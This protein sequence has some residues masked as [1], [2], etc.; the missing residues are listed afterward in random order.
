[1]KVKKYKL[2][3]FLYEV[4]PIRLFSEIGYVVVKK[5]QNVNFK[6]FTLEAVSKNFCSSVTRNLMVFFK[7]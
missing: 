6:H 5:V 3:D 4:L 7:I 2:T 1:M